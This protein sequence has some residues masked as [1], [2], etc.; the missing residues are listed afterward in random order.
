[1]S[2]TNKDWLITPQT[3]TLQRDIQLVISQMNV[4]ISHNVYLITLEPL[5]YLNY[6]KCG[7]KKD[8]NKITTQIGIKCETAD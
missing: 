4:V 5:N 1:M 3:A 7:T 8:N 6:S 2:I